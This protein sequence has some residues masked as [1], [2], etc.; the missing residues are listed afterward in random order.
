MSFPTAAQIKRAVNAAK[1]AGIAVAGFRI[2]PEG[3]IVVFDQSNAPADEYEK[4]RADQA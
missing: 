1:A 3:A 4:W 2:E